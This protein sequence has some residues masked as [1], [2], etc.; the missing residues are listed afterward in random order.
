MPGKHNAGGCGCCDQGP[1]C[2]RNCLR[3]THAVLTNANT[4]NGCEVEN[5]DDLNGTYALSF[6]SG[7]PCL[8]ESIIYSETC[9]NY[10]NEY[11]VTLTVFLENTSGYWQVNVTIRY[12][13][14]E[15]GSSRFEQNN[16][17]IEGAGACPTGTHPITFVSQGT[18]SSGFPLPPIIGSSPDVSLIFP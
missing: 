11:K 17:Y 12:D 5:S 1:D 2:F 4:T 9:T 16:Y 15:G 3:P 7:T 18:G 14:L 6:P 10:S 8:H 13:G